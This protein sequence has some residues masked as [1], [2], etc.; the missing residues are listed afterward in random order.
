MYLAELY[1]HTTGE[2]AALFWFEYVAED[3]L[4]LHGCAR[5]EWRGRIFSLRT[6]DEI[7]TAVA[8][9]GPAIKTVSTTA[10][11]PKI[12]RIF[13]ALGW[14]GDD[15]GVYWSIDLEWDDGQEEAEEAKAAPDFSDGP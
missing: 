4:E 14:E 8:L 1:D 6:L 2:I 10:E 7:W 5:P 3:W 13:R 9:A 11:D 12:A 15:D